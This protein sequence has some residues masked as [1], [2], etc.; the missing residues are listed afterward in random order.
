MVVVRPWRPEGARERGMVVVGTM[1][2]GVPERM[3][4]EKRAG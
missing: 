2:R 4:L 1:R 3:V